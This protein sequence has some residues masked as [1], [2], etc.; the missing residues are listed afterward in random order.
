MALHPA[1][2][3]LVVTRLKINKISVRRFNDSL[4]S[5]SVP[6]RRVSNSEYLFSCKP[7]MLVFNSLDL[8]KY[9]VGRPFYSLIC[10]RTAVK[11]KDKIKVGFTS[12]K[13]KVYIEAVDELW[14]IEKYL[15]KYGGRK[16]AE[17][18]VQ[19]VRS[20][21]TIAQTM[22]GVAQYDITDPSG[23]RLGDGIT[24]IFKK[25]HVRNL[26][27]DFNDYLLHQLNVDRMTL[28]ERSLAKQDELK[29]AYD[30]AQA[31]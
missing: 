5:G 9:L 31:A 22:I 28:H 21:E 4:S 3:P 14:G 29:S 30:E 19:Q 12:Y 25:Y 18:F 7:T 27:E 26:T 10:I 13:D 15:K 23:K 11:L 24:K 8:S 17:A 16:D 2:D 6:D 1:G 20:A